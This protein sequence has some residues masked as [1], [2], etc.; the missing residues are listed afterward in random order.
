MELQQLQSAVSKR[1][2]KSLH[3]NAVKTA[4]V[5]HLV[6]V[7]DQQPGISRVKKG[8]TFGYLFNGREIKDEKILQ[9][10]KK[11]VI[12]PAWENVWICKDENGHLQATGT[13]A[14]G[15]KQYRYHSL[16]TAFRNHTKF[17]HLLE[18]GKRLPHIREQIEKH[19]A[20]ANLNLHKVLAAVV[21]LMEATTIRIG[22][23]SYEKL[24][25]S[26]GLTTLKDRH[27]A[28]NG[29]KV[30]FSFRGKKGVY[31]EIELKSRRLAR[32]IQQCKD[33][34]G[35][36]LFQYYD[37]AGNRQAIDSG[38]VNDYIK[39]ISGGD[40]TAKDFR[41]WTGSVH[42][43]LKLQEIGCCDTAAETKKR[44]AEVL[45]YVAKQLGNTRA[46]CKKYYVHPLILELYENKTISK[47]WQQSDSESNHA[48][49]RLKPIEK[50]LMKILE[51][52]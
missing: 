19:L 24:Y 14:K 45:D 33:I 16:W 10:I 51:T 35:K 2:L 46:V 9:R 31:H 20:Q 52:N 38:M 23:S 6:Y 18:F 1:V 47:Y 25:G 8:K 37:D 15:R 44:I 7:N 30:Q 13:D 43:L 26:F 27:V 22:N 42:A 4:A 34:P 5:I 11:L 41:T 48:A 40:F 17:Y 49:Y 39:T 29:T 28:I 3:T 36:E 32:I 21:K 12:P 50:L